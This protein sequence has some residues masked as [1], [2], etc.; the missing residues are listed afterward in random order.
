MC[1]SL[2]EIYKEL[3]AKHQMQV[4]ICVAG[5][6]NGNASAFN[7]DPEFESLHKSTDLKEVCEL[8]QIPN[9]ESATFYQVGR[10]SRAEGKQLDYCFLSPNLRPYLDPKSVQIY[11]YKDHLG[12]P[13]NPPT[14]LDAKF[15]LPSDHY[16]VI[17]TLQNL[18]LR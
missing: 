1:Q 17:F 16:P 15:N 10:S 18:P 7:T 11:R 5:D 6:F 12:S 8:A 2:I 14:T 9:E 3:E 13:L 4:P